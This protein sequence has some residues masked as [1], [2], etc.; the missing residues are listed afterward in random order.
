MVAIFDSSSP[1]FF[2]FVIFSFIYLFS[3]TE[4]SYWKDASYVILVQ[5]ARQFQRK[6][7][8]FKG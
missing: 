2:N 8:S 6:I 4:R 3:K 5:S 7:K 1:N